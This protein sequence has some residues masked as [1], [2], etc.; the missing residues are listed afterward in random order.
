[1]KTIEF[2]TG[3]KYTAEGQVI[4]ATMHDDGVV[5]FMD[6]GRYIDGEFGLITPAQELTQGLVMSM[7]DNGTYKGT[8]RS[9]RDGMFKGGCNT[10]S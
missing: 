3:R 1:M 8:S 6:H 4:K 10:R 7:Y 9:S 2:N 5:T